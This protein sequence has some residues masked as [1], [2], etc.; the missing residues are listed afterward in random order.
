MQML[1]ELSWERDDIVYIMKLKRHMLYELRLIYFV[2][3][4]LRDLDHEKW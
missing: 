3:L 1:L 4:W 2:P